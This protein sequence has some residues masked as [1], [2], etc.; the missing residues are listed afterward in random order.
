M[1]IYTRTGDE[2]ETGLFGGS[3]VSK[4]IIRLEA[5]GT[6]DELNSALGLVRAEPLSELI[7][8]LLARLQHEL[9]QVGAELGTVKP[10]SRGLR[11]IGR[12][13]IAAIEQAIDEY[14]Q[15]LSPLRNFVLPAGVRA[16]A[17]LH[18]AR[19]ICRRAERR[20]VTLDRSG[21]NEVAPELLAYLNR[22]SDLLFVLA[23]AVNA[24][25][26]V[27]DVVWQSST[28]SR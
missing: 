21:A 5:C 12:A 16:A 11:V 7:D 10:E 20:L 24:E 9:F 25:A 1:T 28:T 2:G 6:V 27:A 23:R 18:L 4:D 22:V 3:R 26:N 17:A 13:N 14:Q 8:S 15:R 19:T